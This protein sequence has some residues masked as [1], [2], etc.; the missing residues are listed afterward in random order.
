MLQNTVICKL[1]HHRARSTTT[2]EVWR[3]DPPRRLSWLWS[4]RRSARRL[5]RDD[6]VPTNYGRRT[7]GPA[8]PQTAGIMEP[9][10]PRRSWWSKACL[11]IPA[12]R[13]HDCQTAY[14]PRA[15]SGHQFHFLIP[16][17]PLTPPC[18][19]AADR[20]RPRAPWIL[21]L[22]PGSAGATSSTGAALRRS[23]R[24]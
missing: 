18:C 8:A 4:R 14:D 15:G 6:D 12:A 24:P 16:L 2:P 20:A 23:P 13:G 19:L 3:G 10:P 1:L 22:D 9:P 21:D 11:G 7:L 17:T 5:I